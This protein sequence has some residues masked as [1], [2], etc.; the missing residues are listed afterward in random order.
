LTSAGGGFAVAKMIK[1]FLEELAID[2]GFA[3]RFEETPIGVM[4]EFDL[5]A[6]QRKLI[7]NGTIADIRKKVEE[8]LGPQS[9]SDPVYVIRVKRG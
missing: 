2:E 3:A 5:D 4:V 9:A 6:D 1:D 7:M 8:E